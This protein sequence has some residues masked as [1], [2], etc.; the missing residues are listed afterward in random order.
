MTVA[1][2]AMGVLVTGGFYA[3]ARNDQQRC[4]AGNEFRRQDLP[5]AFDL[6]S[7]F[8]GGELGADPADVADARRRFAGQLDDL[9]PARS[10]SLWP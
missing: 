3:Q 4:V 5:R 1:W 9:F 7:V 2:V 10:C 6:Y 8:L